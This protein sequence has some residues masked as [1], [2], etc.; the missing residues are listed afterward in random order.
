MEKF[1]NFPFECLEDIFRHLSFG[2]LLKC[3]LVC[4]DWNEFIGSTRF[5]IKK[6]KLNC[7]TYD[8]TQGH[9]NKIFINSNR[10]YECLRLS[11]NYSK[12]L[13]EIF[14]AKRCNWTN[15]R[16]FVHFKTCNSFLEFMSVFQSTVQKLECAGNIFSNTESEVKS[17]TLSTVL[18]FP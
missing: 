7:R 17:K 13:L 9:L 16:L 15:V 6:I 8:L 3:T 10:K 11:G 18:E 4:P 14:L 1:E 5:C 12:K 2:D